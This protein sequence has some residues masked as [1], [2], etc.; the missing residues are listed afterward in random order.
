VRSI[1][2][3]PGC[4]AHLCCTSAEK[5]TAFI[6]NDGE[7]LKIENDED[8]SLRCEYGPQVVWLGPRDKPHDKTHDMS[9]VQKMPVLSQQEYLVVSENLTGT[10]KNVLGPLLYQ[11]GPHDTYSG[12]KQALNLAKN[13]YV[14]IKDEMGKYRIV[15][16][17]ARVIPEP[18]ETVIAHEQAINVDAHTAVLV[19]NE[20]D[21][22]LELVTMETHFEGQP[23]IFIPLPYQ[24]ILET[25][26]KIILE[27]Y[28][29]MCFKDRHGTFHYRSGK[30]DEERSFFL[31][32]FCEEVVQEWST[33]LKKEHA[34]FER[35]WRFD[36]RPAYMNYEFNCRT[37]DNVELVVDVSFY[38]Q[39]LNIKAMIEHTADAPGDI[40]THARSKIIQ[41]V[42]N[43]TLMQFL[44]SFN[45]IIRE[46]AGVGSRQEITEQLAA[47]GDDGHLA[48][49]MDGAMMQASSAPRVETMSREEEYKGGDRQDA[50]YHHHHHIDTFYVK[51]GVQ[52]LSVEVLQFKCSNPDTDK[53]LQAIIKETADRLKKKEYQRGENEMAIS[54]LKGEIEQEKL[55]KDLIE[56]KKSHLKTEAKIEGEGV[57]AFIAG[58]SGQENID[59][60]KRRKPKLEKEIGELQAEIDKAREEGDE[61]KLLEKNSKLGD[62][63]IELSLMDTE[64]ADMHERFNREHVGSEKAIEIYTMLRKLDSIRLMSSGNAGLYVTPQDVNLTVGQLFPATK[65]LAGHTPGQRH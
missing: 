32:P 9:A 52:L 44:E 62:M 45:D 6:L 25:R 55:N 35:M 33:D 57:A 41:S 37:I 12:N 60:L 2:N 59:A 20:N 3:G 15:R 21:G 51:R 5:R 39:I 26:P 19:R 42:S 64:M 10:Q 31:E 46:G 34:T 53:T 43:T 23:G 16:G 36:M 8:G 61:I 56:I 54:K 27:E 29:D 28:E 1:D 11:P 30:K 17:E 65:G 63:T 4:F 58:I 49:D 40:C 47:E 38:W 48:D 14:K 13:E 22:S 7:W 18:L 24:V 50:H